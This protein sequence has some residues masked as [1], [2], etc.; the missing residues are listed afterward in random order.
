MAGD[1]NFDGLIDA[2]DYSVWRNSFG[3]TTALAADGDGS[4]QI[5]AGDYDFWKRHFGETAVR[6][7]GAGGGVPEPPLGVVLAMGIPA[8]LSLRSRR[9]SLRRSDIGR[10]LLR[11]IA[12]D[13]DQLDVG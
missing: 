4:R 13:V 5:D 3:S 12:A 10:G 1:Y 11:Q 7:T 6:P 2:A 9:R 8:M